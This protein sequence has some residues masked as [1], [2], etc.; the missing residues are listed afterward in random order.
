[1]TPAPLA[2]CVFQN[3]M[4]VMTSE[5]VCV[6]HL[7]GAWYKNQTKCT[8]ARALA[9]G[10][11]GEKGGH[12]V[13]VGAKVEKPIA[14]NWVFYLAYGL[15]GFFVLLLIIVSILYFTSGSSS[16]KPEVSGAETITTT[17]SGLSPQ[18]F[19]SPPSVY[20]STSSYLSTLGAETPYS[21]Q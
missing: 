9:G 11:S 3:G 17:I 10:G 5:D 6:N 16:K 8:E 14:P 12:V 15:A 19:T 18:T 7:K 21:I 1:V 2:P 4:C 13:V 20:P